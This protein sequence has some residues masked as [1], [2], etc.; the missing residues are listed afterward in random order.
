M[1]NGQSLHGIKSW[2]FRIIHT[3]SAH[4]NLK[5]EVKPGGRSDIDAAIN[6]VWQ[7]VD[8]LIDYR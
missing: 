2:E 1:D 6:E 8:A 5:P 4:S 3:N 7:R